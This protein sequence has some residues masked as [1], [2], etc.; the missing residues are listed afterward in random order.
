MEVME[1]MS[2]W[3]GI[4]GLSLI[5]V[6]HNFWDIPFIIYLLLQFPSYRIVSRVPVCFADLFSSIYFFRGK[7]SIW[8][9]QLGSCL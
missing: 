7:V 4:L 8:H 2:G 6:Y 3:Q 5:K 1:V 9:R